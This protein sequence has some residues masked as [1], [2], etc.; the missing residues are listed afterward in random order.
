MVLMLTSNQEREAVLGCMLAGADGYVVK[1]SGREELC[2]ALE[3]VADGDKFLDPEVTAIVL[4]QLSPI[5]TP[6][7]QQS[8]LSPRECETLELLSRGLTNRQISVELGIR[9]KVARNYVAKILDKLGFQRRAQAAAWAS[10]NR[11]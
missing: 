8:S 2:R 3:R 11:I 4:R 5:H 1:K 6:S 10:H 9:E 7:S